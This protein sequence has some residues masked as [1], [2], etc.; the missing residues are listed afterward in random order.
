MTSLKKILAFIFIIAMI[1]IILYFTPTYTNPATNE[2]SQ[3]EAT[4]PT[5]TTNTDNIVEDIV[6]LEPVS[7]QYILI[8]T[9]SIEELEEELAYCQNNLYISQLLIDFAIDLGYENTD[10]FLQVIYRDYQNYQSYIQ[11]Y[12]EKISEL[13]KLK[14]EEPDQYPAA[15]YIWNYMKA[16]GWSDYVCAG[17]I[18]NIM[19]ETGGRTLNINYDFD[20]NGYY[21]ICCWSKKYHPDVVGLD[22]EGQCTYLVETVEKIMNT[23]GRLY[24]KG[25]TFED[26]LDAE[27]IEEAANAFMVVY[28]RPGYKKSPK[29]VQNG[30][31][32]YEYFVGG[33]LNG[34]T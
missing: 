32:A 16:Q 5:E 10:D 8:E 17:I 13:N 23:Y 18:G 14:P 31:K 33:N 1:C 7:N 27:S 30:E 25:Y 11:Y 22:L 26:F 2:T 9:D 3:T 12:E 19:Q 4:S 28:E 15:T 6:V 20:G 24:Q 21:G 34:A 29:R